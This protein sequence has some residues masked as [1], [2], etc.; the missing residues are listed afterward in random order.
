MIKL[1]TLCLIVENNRILL[2]MKKRGFGAGHWNGYGGK[3]N[4]GESIEEAASR[5]VKEE[6]AL[7]PIE[8]VQQGIVTFKGEEEADLEVHIFRIT[9]YTGE[10]KESEEMKPKWFLIDEIPYDEMWPDDRY[11]LPL[12]L[13][14]KNFIG[15]FTY[16]EGVIVDYEVNVADFTTQ[17]SN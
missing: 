8:I 9:K 12:F 17:I 3:L 15:Q 6:I 1:L 14:G 16:K 11:W 13:E 10:P 5:E 2:A 7:T 4:P